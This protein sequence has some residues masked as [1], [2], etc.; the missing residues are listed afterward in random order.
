L[1]TLIASKVTGRMANKLLRELHVTPNPDDPENPLLD[2]K[3]AWV[4]REA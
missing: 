3:P 1:L 4:K 2:G